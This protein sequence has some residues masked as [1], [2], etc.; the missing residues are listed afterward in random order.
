MDA[1][2]FDTISRGLLG[3]GT[4]RQALQALVAGGLGWGLTQSLD[5]DAKKKKHRKRKK[6]RRQRK[7]KRCLTLGV[8]CN[9]GGKRRCCD[10]LSCKV[11]P[12]NTQADCCLELGAICDTKEDCCEGTC[13]PNL[14]GGATRHCRVVS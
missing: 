7:H 5:A 6:R 12:G 14:I 10:N 3:N 11:R 8:T 9:P 13:I 1:H 2:V 4:R